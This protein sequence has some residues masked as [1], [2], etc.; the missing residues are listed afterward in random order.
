MD[1]GSDVSGEPTASIF[2][3]VI[4]ECYF[5]ADVS[6]GL[7]TPSLGSLECYS[8]GDVSGD[9]TVSHLQGSL[10]RMA[11]CCRRFEAV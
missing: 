1:V 3:A 2:K 7:L 11:V 8:D 6:S 10:R 9:I 4:N 5:L